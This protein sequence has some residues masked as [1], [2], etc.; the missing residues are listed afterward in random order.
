MENKSTVYIHLAKP[1]QVEI[2]EPSLLDS[3]ES[4]RAKAFKFSTDRD[5]Y[6]ASHIFLRRTLSKYAS[7][8]PAEWRFKTNHYGKPHISNS[9][10]QQLQFSLSH[11]Q[12]MIACVVSHEH[13]VGI[14]VEKNRSLAD[15][16]ALCQYALSPL[17]VRNVRSINSI[18]EKES[19]FFTYWTLKEAYVKAK[20]LGL[21]MS[22]Q[23]FTF[24]QAA[25][26]T[27]LLCIE[28]AEQTKYMEKSWQFET[29]LMKDHHLAVGAQLVYNVRGKFLKRLNSCFFFQEQS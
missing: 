2:T 22:L 5:L 11:T 4:A 18:K 15:L 28:A 12:G 3:T 13:P 1:E 10:D 9:S 24:I 6:V 8:E 16:N 23:E 7:V 25:N 19:R 20:G 26:S 27:W 21:S 29:R 14:D 17:E